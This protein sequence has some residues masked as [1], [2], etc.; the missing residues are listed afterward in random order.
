[1]QTTNIIE[2]SLYLKGID[3]NYYNLRTK[4]TNHCRAHDM[5]HHNFNLFYA[6]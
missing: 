3:R 4:N 5:I 1:M 6:E 2:E